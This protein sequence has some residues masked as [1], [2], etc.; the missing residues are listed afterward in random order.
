MSAA[1]KNY[2]FT[3]K[4]FGR[5]GHTHTP[6]TRPLHTHDQRSMVCGVSHTCICTGR[7]I[8]LPSFSFYVL[9]NIYAVVLES[10]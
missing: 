5:H 4:M 7:L 10:R 2:S 8:R 9:R 3:F 1:L 6:G